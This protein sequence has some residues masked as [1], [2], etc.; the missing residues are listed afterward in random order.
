M[1]GHHYVSVSGRGNGAGGGSSNRRRKDC[2]GLYACFRGGKRCSCSDVFKCV[3][4]PQESERVLEKEGLG[5]NEVVKRGRRRL[6]R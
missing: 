6:G 5:S 4:V 2:F 3:S 1:V